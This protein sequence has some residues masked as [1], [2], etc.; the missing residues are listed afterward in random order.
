MSSEISTDTD[1]C[2]ASDSRKELTTQGLYGG[3]I[4]IRIPASFQDVST[5]REVKYLG[6]PTLLSEDNHAKHE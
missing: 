5:I 2:Q 6:F 4:T 1:S 3:A